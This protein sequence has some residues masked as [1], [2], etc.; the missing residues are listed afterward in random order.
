[1]IIDFLNKQNTFAP[2]RP[3]LICNQVKLTYNELKEKIL[4]TAYQLIENGIKADSR[5]LVLSENN[6]EYVV[7]IF[8]LWEISAI[9]IPLNIR[10]KDED[11][12]QLLIHSDSETILIHSGSDRRLTTLDN[13]I[14]RIIF[15]LK[16]EP[17]S[18][19]VSYKNKW[20]EKQ[21]ALILYTS[22]T[23]SSPKGVIHTFKSLISNTES[24]NLYFH[25]NYLD[26]WLVSLPLYHIGGL[27][28]LTRSIMY[29]SELIIPD[30]L[31]TPGIIDA[32]RNYHPNLISIVQTT[33]TRLI[34]YNFSYNRQFT[35]I[36]GGGPSND[37]IVSDGI[38]RG[39][40]IVKVYG[41][42]ETASMISAF[43][44]NSYQDKIKS[45]GRPFRKNS[46]R[47]IDENGNKLLSNEIGEIVFSGESLMQGYW[48]NSIETNRRIIDHEYLTGDFGYIDE[49]GFLFISS[50]RD[51]LIISG[52]ENI[53]PNEIEDMIRIIPC[54]KD[55]CV[56]GLDNKEWGQVIAAAI[57]LEQVNAISSNEFLDL[58]KPKLP[59]FKLP[60]KILFIDEL[61]FNSLGKIKRDEVRKLF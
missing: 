24:A 6:W 44:V 39:W 29:G 43:S 11:L 58:L 59:S 35:F 20:N 13:K 47:I 56:V 34:E 53:N 51:D 26:K 48:N 55:V 31:K 18:I 25:F 14:K 36:L 27:Q 33:L 42:T 32:I 1:M 23:T 30:S 16:S 9:P 8:A 3:A 12:V 28:I 61:P 5:V 10:L 38:K 17:R 37:K 49:D 7:L 60:K 2:D 40:K 41:S 19:T 50:R 45:S 4:Q 54:V 15:P 57:I 52:G 22:G 46:M 21:T